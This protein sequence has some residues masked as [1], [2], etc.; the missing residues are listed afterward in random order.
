MGNFTGSRIDF[1]N[2]FYEGELSTDKANGLGKLC[3]RNGWTFEGVFLDDEPLENQ[4]F[5]KLIKDDKI[6]EACY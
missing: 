2:Y 3:F 6:F 4:K 1:E 5:G